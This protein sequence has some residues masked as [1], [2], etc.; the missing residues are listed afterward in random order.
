MAREAVARVGLVNRAGHKPGQ[1]SSGEQQRITIARAI[2]H[3]PRVLLADEPTGNLDR[4]TA[5]TLM[6]LINDIR[7]DTGMT[8]L[9]VTHDEALAAQYGDR[10]LRMRDGELV[11]L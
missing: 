3:R 1:L 11:D 6:D 10:M 9:M 2:V 8:V 4:K 5:T 7:Q